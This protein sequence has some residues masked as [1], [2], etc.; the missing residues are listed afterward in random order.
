MA[1]HGKN[2]RKSTYDK[3]SAPRSGDKKSSNYKQSKA[4]SAAVKARHAKNQKP[5]KTSDAFG[6]W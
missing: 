2:T 6:L 4:G 1:S 5:K 3:H